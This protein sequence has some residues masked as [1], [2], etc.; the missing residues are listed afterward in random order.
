MTRPLAAVL[1]VSLLSACVG[2]SGAPNT[3]SGPKRAEACGAK[4]FQYLVGNPRSDIP[5]RPKGANWRVYSTKEVITM[6]Y[7]YGR[8]NIVWDADTSKVTSVHCG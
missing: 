4:N 6:D 5:Y 8:M 3:A 1:L 7:V 2:Y